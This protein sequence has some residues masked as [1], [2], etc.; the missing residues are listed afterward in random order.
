MKTQELL[1]RLKEFGYRFSPSLFFDRVWYCMDSHYTSHP[2]ASL[3]KQTIVGFR[4][5]T[6]TSGN[7]AYT[8][9][10]GKHALEILYREA[11][12]ERLGL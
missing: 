7:A 9:R 1:E 2:N 12:K 11:I 5:F 8:T 6:V 3:G 4:G 10:S